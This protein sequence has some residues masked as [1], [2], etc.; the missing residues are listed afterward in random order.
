LRVWSSRW[1]QSWTVSSM[2][3]NSFSPYETVNLS[4]RVSPLGTRSSKP[5]L[6]YW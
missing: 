5:Y 3:I 4:S 2:S 1:R 6:K